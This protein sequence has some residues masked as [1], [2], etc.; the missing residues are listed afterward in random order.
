MSESRTVTFTRKALVALILPLIAE[1]FLA[2]MVG[3]ADTVMVTT[4]G[5][6]AVSAVSLV[7]SLNI[8]LIQLFSAMGAG[9]AIVS[10]QYLGHGDRKNACAAGG[11]L[12]TSSVAVSLII[13]LP[14]ALFPRAVLGLIYGKVD[15]GIL[16]EAEKYF[17]ISALSYPFLALYN[18]GVGLLRA[19][20]NSKTS[21]W[22][23][24]VMNVI[25]IAGNAL[26]IWGLKM[27]AAGAA[28]ASLVS[29]AVSAVIIFLVLRNP[30]MPVF[31][32]KRNLMTFDRKMILRIMGVGLPSGMENSLFQVGKLLIARLISQMAASIIAAN[33]ISN[34]I[35]SVLN[36][37]G[38]AIALAA[39][40]VVGQC[41]GAGDREHAL[42]YGR[43]LMLLEFLGVI[44][45]NLIAFFFAGGIVSLFHISPEGSAAAVEVVRLYS[46]VSVTLWVFSFGL[47]NTL[48]AAGDTKFTM[49]VS[50][51]SMLTLRLGLSYILVDGLG[52]GLNGVWY[53]M[54]ADW[55]VR[56]L[57][58]FIRFRNHKWLDRRVI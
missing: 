49:T 1:Q 53:A 11:Q 46:V 4:A 56:S 40:A 39:I 7:D 18:S 25:N 58:F 48:R 38:S 51:I 31:L 55:A 20:G 14:G 30:L 36:I 9:G 37:P 32:T 16:A 45:A 29:R 42:K 24:T 8:L 34:S 27:G 44:P 5:E 35:C 23:S 17:M 47:P 33:A 10:A 28:T 41:I 21:M 3:M 52:L 13:A 15:P 12:V 43:R 26:L 2:V 19:M 6:N 50:V 57:C 54:Y 22:T